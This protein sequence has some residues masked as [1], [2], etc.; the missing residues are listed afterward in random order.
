MDEFQ[1]EFNQQSPETP[2]NVNSLGRK[3]KIEWD[4]YMSMPLIKYENNPFLEW[5]KMKI[6][7]PLLFEI[8]MKYC[9]VMGTSVPS[10]RMFSTTGRIMQTRCNLDPER[11]SKLTVLN[12]INDK[13][14]LNII[15]QN[16]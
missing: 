12:S 16:E 6:N 7:C 9:V 15:R 11:L 4:I 5:Q 2:T 8:A 13:L 1:A 10:E 14:L 3:L